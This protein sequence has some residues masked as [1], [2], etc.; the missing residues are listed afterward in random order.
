[1]TRV[2]NYNRIANRYDFL[3]RIVFGN[4]LVTAQNHFL[5]DLVD[6][7]R[8][9]IF[10]G[11]TGAMIIPLLKLYPCTSIHFLESS[12]AMISKAKA[13][14]TSENNNVSFT[15]GTEQDL[16]DKTNVYDVVIT[17]FVL[18]VF[19]EKDIENV[20]KL[21]FNALGS[22][23]RWIHTD[24]YVDRNSPGWQNMMIWLM[25]RFFNITARQPNQMLLNFDIYFDSFPLHQL[26]YRSF[27]HQ[28][29]RTNLYEKYQENEPSH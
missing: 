23:G 9:L 2:P 7:R 28:M 8:I 4:Q 19:K 16:E 6:P 3:G 21:L 1:M 25:Y 15:C 13:R 12:A 17:P 29:M 24:F 18:D 20:L 22:G 14:I 10:G 11:G 27:Y 26:A 5:S